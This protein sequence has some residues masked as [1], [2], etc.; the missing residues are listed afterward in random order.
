MPCQRCGTDFSFVIQFKTDTDLDDEFPLYH[1]GDTVPIAPNIYE[2]I[3]RGYCPD[4][5]VQYLDLEALRSLQHLARAAANGT[6]SIKQN[7]KDVSPDQLISLAPKHHRSDVLIRGLLSVLRS[8]SVVI[9]GDF[10]GTFRSVFLGLQT[11]G[12]PVSSM[13]EFEVQVDDRNIISA[14]PNW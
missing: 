5:Q 7:G 3:G 14:T 2:G 12:W 1:E 8:H 10:R 6:V 11:E 9:G 4:C 13:P